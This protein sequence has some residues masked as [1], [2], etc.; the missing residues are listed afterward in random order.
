LDNDTSLL[1]DLVVDAMG[2]TSPTRKFLSKAGYEA[3]ETLE[4]MIHLSYASMIFEM[5]PSSDPP[6][7][8]IFSERIGLEQKIDSGLVAGGVPGHNY[9]LFTYC[10]FGEHRPTCDS[11]ESFVAWAK[12][13]ASMEL[14]DALMTAIHPMT[15]IKVFTQRTS[16]WIRWDKMALMPKN[17]LI[18]GDSACALNPSFGQGMTVASKGI[19]A[20]LNMVPQILA[21]GECRTAQRAIGQVA[22]VPFM[23]N[24]VEDHRHKSTEGYKPPLT[25]AA[26][27]VNKAVFRAGAH[28]AK[29]MDAIYKVAGMESSPM[30]L[31]HP[32]IVG[33][34]LWDVI[35]RA[36]FDEKAKNA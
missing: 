11:P 4:V 30:A 23:M 28:D 32:S 2:R 35:C 25:D 15:P 34:V 33:R 27:H 3:P 31:L 26:L 12:T 13:L 18:V 17:L 8:T 16:T 10:G 24:A 20:L 7:T 14:Y 36:I 6:I 22:F 21:D 5:P 29:V 1:A 9:S 19:R